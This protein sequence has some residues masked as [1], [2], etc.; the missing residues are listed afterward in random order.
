MTDHKIHKISTR[1]DALHYYLKHFDGDSERVI[2]VARAGF[3]EVFQKLM[4]SRNTETDE[5]VLQFLKNE[6]VARGAMA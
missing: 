3:K 6:A 1:E 5:E 2:E 4:F